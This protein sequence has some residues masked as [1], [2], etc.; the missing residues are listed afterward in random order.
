MGPLSLSL[1]ERKGELESFS[2]LSRFFTFYENYIRVHARVILAEFE[3][4]FLVGVNT[5]SSN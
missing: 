1:R 4:I 3:L 5:R 2:A